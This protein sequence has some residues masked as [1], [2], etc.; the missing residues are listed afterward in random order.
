MT[1]APSSGPDAATLRV[2]GRLGRYLLLFLALVL[3]TTVRVWHLDG[4]ALWADEGNNAYFSQSSLSQLVEM[5]RLSHDTDPPAHR[6]V[7]SAWLRVLGRSAFNARLLSVAMGVA[8]VLL[9]CSW[10]SWLSGAPVGF[11]A[12]ALWA[13]APMAIYYTRE[14]KGYP[15]VALF[16]CLAVYLW[17]RF[18]YRREGRR[19]LL[20]LLYVACSVLSLGAHYYAILLHVAQGVWLLGQL[21]VAE[22]RASVWRELRAWLLAQLFIGAAILP[23]VLM[24]YSSATEG[25]LGLRVGRPAWNAF[26]YAQEAGRVLAAGKLGYGWPAMVALAVVA[27]A[28]LWAIWRDRRPQVTLLVCLV[29][30]PLLGAFALQTVVPFFSPRFLLYVLPPLFLLVAIGIVHL[31]GIGG[32]LV[33]A[34]AMA[35]SLVM[36]MAFDLSEE[37]QADLRPI[38]D[39]L[40]RL[41]QPDDGILTTYIWQQGILSLYAPDVEGP[42]YLDWYDRGTVEAEM[43]ALF[44]RHPRLWLLTYRVP[45]AN[46][47]NLAGWWLEE[48]ATRAL[49]VRYDT[50]RLGLYVKDCSDEWSAHQTIR[51][52]KGIRADFAP[53]DARVAPGQLLGL[54]VRW[55]V[56]DPPKLQY[57][58]FVHLVD[59][60]GN[61]QTQ[62]DGAPRNGFKPFREFAPGE[63]V[64]DCRVLLIPTEAPPGEYQ[65][66]IGLYVPKTGDRLGV[67]DGPKVGEGQA[68]IGKV[69]VGEPALRER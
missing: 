35:W 12:A 3:A 14:A 29:A 18:L 39:H 36:P 40:A 44:A 53:L 24:T 34:L 8:T 16:G 56:T 23:G 42:Y 38:A 59:A 27:V 58:A 28:A 54:R 48:H 46:P 64:T 51:F 17:A 1:D 65:V 13:L 33:L 25:A 15:Q 61:I 62:H 5:S 49:R 20:W 43:E 63:Q 47:V 45:I 57:S 68:V 69:V 6:L 9:L 52:D 32:A 31:R 55:T 30:V 21:A 60:Q 37:D 50:H 4:P 7:L 67:L 26:E 41:W 10:G 2:G 22:D 66:R 19:S 11:T